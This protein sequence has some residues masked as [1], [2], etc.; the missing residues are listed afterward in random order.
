MGI[1]RKVSHRDIDRM[2]G[3]IADS[4][5]YGFVTNPDEHAEY[6]AGPGEDRSTVPPFGARTARALD[7]YGRGTPRWL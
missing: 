7:G 6:P 4:G 1:D 3:M 2:L 5:S